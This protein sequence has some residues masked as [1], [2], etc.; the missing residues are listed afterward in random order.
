MAI[1][2]GPMLSVIA[3][4]SIGDVVTFKCGRVIGKKKFKKDL[5]ANEL[6]E[7]QQLFKNGAAVWSEDLTQAVK[8]EWFKVGIKNYWDLRCNPQLM[9]LPFL[10]LL[11]A[12]PLL[13]AL[14]ILFFPGTN[15]YDLWMS[16]Y[17]TLG[18]SGWPNYPLPPPIGW[19]PTTTRRGKTYWDKYYEKIK[20]S[21]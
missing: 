16:Y 15:G 9:A 10:G 12:G 18:D 4:G 20:E 3:R 14:G 6:S 21:N 5:R 8:D 11:P 2:V 19:V 13:I 17:L 7:Q 1:L